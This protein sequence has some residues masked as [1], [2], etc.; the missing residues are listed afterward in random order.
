MKECNKCKKVYEANAGYCYDCE[1]EAL[2][3]IKMEKFKNAGGWLLFFILWATLSVIIGFVNVVR[4]IGALS[5]LRT[6]PNVELGGAFPLLSI[7]FALIFIAIV[8]LSLFIAQVCSRKSR[9]LFF[10]QL[11][12]FIG[13]LGSILILV[14]FGMI[15]ID[16]RPIGSG[17]AIRDLIVAIGAFILFTAYYNSSDR[18]RIYMETNDYLRH[19]IIAHKG[20]PF[21]TL[22][23]EAAAAHMQQQ[24]QQ[25]TAA[26]HMQQQQNTT[27]AHTPAT[28]K[29]ILGKN[30]VSCKNCGKEY[31]NTRDTC[32]F[33][34]AHNEVA[35]CENCNNKYDAKHNLC[36]HCG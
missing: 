10:Y 9:F 35:V 18:V 21:R 29:P 15:T 34:K 6:L 27:A 22:T 23:P 32:P 31:I 19:A 11:Q 30:L 17:A 5:T 4:S 28:F 16:G 14:A 1:V 36:P 24:Q 7:G 25:N 20:E 33:C 12:F 8:A 3:S 26:A 13:L 2:G